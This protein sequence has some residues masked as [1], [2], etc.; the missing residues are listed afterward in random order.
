MKNKIFLMLTA[1]VVSLTS[2]TNQDA[3]FDNFEKQSV[4]FAYQYPVRTITLGEDIFDTTLDNQHKCKIMGTLGGVYSNDKDITIDVEVA[5]PLTTG[6]LFKGAGDNVL[7]MPSNYY[8]L[9][10]N[11]M[12]IAK[13]QTSG[14]IDVQLTDAFFADPLAVKNTYVIP[15]KMTN[16]VNAD[17]ILSGKALV[18]NP[19]R[20]IA[21]DW[22]VAPKDFIFYAVKYVNP[23]HGFYLRRGKDIVTKDNISTTEERK[24]EYV[25]YDEVV[26]LSTSSLSKL[27]FPITNYKS[28]YGVNLNLKVDIT[29]DQNQKCIV[30][31]RETSYQLNDSTTVYNISASGNGSFVKKGEIKSWGNKD[32][33]AM[34]I[35]YTVNYTVKTSFPKKKLPDDI[36]VVKYVT[37]D[38]LVLRDRGVAAE[39]FS[40]V[41]K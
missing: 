14:G 23:W 1:V 40:P 25:E 33:D 18:A 39:V 3:E 24:K 22:A 21:G 9:L 32:R 5:N 38:I 6:L 2:C 15:L 7:A 30:N 8:T 16:V 36:Q 12:V 31:Q 37:N 34:Y 41:K 10:S 4:Y 11:K 20:A 26:K 19:N 13:G 29:L 35:D 27:V 28:K 17:S